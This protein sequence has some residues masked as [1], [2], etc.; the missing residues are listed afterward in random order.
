MRSH[1][2]HPRNA[3][4]S[5][6]ATVA[7]LALL[8][9]PVAAANAAGPGASGPGSV[10]SLST[11]TPDGWTNT[12][13]PATRT[14]Q[15]SVAPTTE[16]TAIVPIDE[17]ADY[18]SG[19]CV[20]DLSALADFTQVSSLTGCGQTITV[21]PTAMKLSVSSSW[22]T[23]GSSPYT[24]SAYPN[25]LYT[26]GATSLKLSFSSRVGV[27]GVEAEPNPGDVHAMT[28]VFKRGSKTLGTVTRDINGASGA[29]ILGGRMKKPKIKSIKISSDVDFAI[30]KIRVGPTSGELSPFDQPTDE[31]LEDMCL[32]DL[33]ELEL[34]SPV[35][36]VRMP[37]QVCEV[38]K[39]S[40]SSPAGPD[41]LSDAL[42]LLVLQV[43]GGWPSWGSPPFT[44]DANPRVL[45]TQGQ[46]SVVMTFGGEG[47]YAGTNCKG[48]VEV[49]PAGLEDHQFEGVF[50]DYYG[51]VLGTVYVT[52]NG[53]A[54]ARLL[55]AA[56]TGDPAIKSITVTDIST[57]VAP[58]G[59]ALAQLYDCAAESLR[60]HHE[61]QRTRSVSTR[62]GTTRVSPCSTTQTSSRRS[63][64]ST[65]PT[66]VLSAA[67]TTPRSPP[68]PGHRCR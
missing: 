22:A 56:L 59:F 23:W 32:A 27:A 19:T 68:S 8:A 66:Q 53:N 21:S 14:G 55:G 54:G 29:R 61:H 62:S 45:S 65:S 44:Q 42:P 38:H 10:L 30:A 15:G 5:G 39:V 28:A 46:T 52:A 1:S 6:T 63:P 26:Q 13:T 24:E 12:G 34:D 25:V 18:P 20:I 67:S 41:G 48:G 60:Q 57:A 43:P 58:G 50:R 11:P 51:N 2:D 49:Q 33:S 16:P 35:T 40:F 9:T 17:H 47:G 7:V 4:R 37:G 31:Y 64:P 3:L 36:V